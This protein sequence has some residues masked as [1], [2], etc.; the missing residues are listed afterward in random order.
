LPTFK[1]K[2]MMILPQSFL[3]RLYGNHKFYPAI[4]GINIDGGKIYVWSSA[5]DADLKFIIDIYDMKFRR[6]GRSSYYNYIKKSC[7]VI[8]NNKLYTL[9]IRSDDKEYKELLS[10]IA[11]FNEPYKLLVY[12]INSDTN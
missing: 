3:S 10:R 4:F 11:F 9:N 7:V 2:E 5:R 6:L 1:D 8:K 12:E